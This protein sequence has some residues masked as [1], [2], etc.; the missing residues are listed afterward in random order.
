LTRDLPREGLRKE[1]PLRRKTM[2]ERSIELVETEIPDFGPPD[3]EPR[4]HAEEYEWRVAHARQRAADLGLDVLV[5]YGDREHCANLS[6]LCGYDPRFEESLLIVPKDGLPALLVGNEGMGYSEIG[7]LKMR[8]VLYQTFSLLGQPRDKSPRLGDILRE[9]GVRPGARVGLAGWKYFDARESD[10]PAHCLETPAF[11][12]EA[13]R[14]AAGGREQ[15]VNATEIFMHPQDGLRAVNSAGQLGCFEFAATYASQGV[16][17]IIERLRPNVT[18]YEAARAAGLN[19]IPLSCHQMLS[20]GPRARWGLPSPSSRYLRLGDPFTTALGL[21]GA[22]TARAGFL[23][24]DETELPAAI[25][26]YVEALVKPYFA[27]AVEWYETI[28]IGVP[29][30]EIYELIR[31]RLG[32]PKFGVSLNPGHLLH[33]DEWVH[34]PFY[35]G[36]PY[37]LRSGMAIQC[38]IIPATG[39]DY[40]TT[41]IEDGIA[42]ADEVLRAEFAAK[43]R[44]A[45]ARVEKRRAFM[46]DVLGIRLKPE[47]LPLS[48][49][50]AVLAPYLLSPR[51]ILRAG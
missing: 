51:R 28:G 3:F 47:V 34:S 15:V 8:R 23:V 11:I 13:L 33:I 20:A 44:T 26:D 6:F 27:A 36:S 40:F 38:D 9:S 22:L 45:W 25:R 5:V 7:P 39:T 17:N 49:M 29:A 50:P 18:E 42:L 2:A 30:R 24:R 48:N 31:R 43:Y 19:G 41:N 37:T 35:A 14:E 12:V 16:R 21:Q 32:D 4:L 10:D 1:F 46:R